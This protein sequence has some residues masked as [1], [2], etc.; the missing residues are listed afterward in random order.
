MQYWTSSFAV[1]SD[2]VYFL[3]LYFVS[4]Q[5]TM[6][7]SNKKCVQILASSCDHKHCV[8]HSLV[9]SLVGMYYLTIPNASLFLRTLNTG[10]H[11]VKSTIKKTKF[12]EIL[13][14]ELL[15]REGKKTS[16]LGMTYYCLAVIGSEEVKT[17]ATTSGPLLRYVDDD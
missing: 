4:N 1:I 9:C 14:T 17:V 16:K 15:L 12:K 6:L 7:G 10:L 2:C 8:C 13:L 5:I 11:Y 3:V